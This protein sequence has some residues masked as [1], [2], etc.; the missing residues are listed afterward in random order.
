MLSNIRDIAIILWVIAQGLS[1]FFPGSYGMFEA[2]AD[3][4]YYH[5]TEHMNPWAD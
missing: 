3:S 2:Q 5:Y 4:G 1:W